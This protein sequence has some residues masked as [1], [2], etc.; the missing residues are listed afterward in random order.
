MKRSDDKTLWHIHS[1]KQR[2]RVKEI[3]SDMLPG[4]RAGGV[5]A[6]NQS[7]GGR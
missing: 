5:Q 1:V 7:P 2:E 3:Q 6:A 4:S